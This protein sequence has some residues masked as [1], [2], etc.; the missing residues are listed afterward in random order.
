MGGYGNT[1]MS[2]DLIATTQRK[3][4]VGLGATGLSC[5]RYLAQ[6][7]ADFAVWDTRS[8]PPGLDEL[9]RIAP[10]APVFTGEQAP[11]SVLEGAAELVVSPGV[12]LDV[13]AIAAAAEAGVDVIGD[14]DLFIR[15]ARAP[16]I[17]I[18]GSNAKSTVTAM[19][20]AMAEAAGLNVGVGGN[21]G[22]PA[23]DLLDDARELYV[24]ELS[25]FQLERSQPLG[26][27]VATVLNISADHL[28]RHG[29][30]TRYHAAKHRIFRQ[31]RAAVLHRDDPLTLPLVPPDVQQ[32]SW[33]L[34]EP[35][36][37]GFGL[38]EHEGETWLCR[39]FDAWLPVNELALPGRHNVANALAALVLGDLAGLPLEPMLQAL[40]NFGG[41]PHRCQRVADIDGV[42]YIDD[43]KGTNTAATVA[44][45]EGLGGERDIVLI[46]GGQAKGADLSELG[47]ALAAHGRALVTLG[48]AAPELENLFADALP[49]ERADSMDDAVTRAAQIA[50]AGQTV[51]L[52]PACASLDMFDNYR[53]RGDAFVAAVRAL[54]GDA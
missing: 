19:V 46:A 49:T 16:V 26:L 42:T 52:S 18:T 37:K 48:E 39:G 29:D 11:V 3:V 43:S 10:D 45:L 44:A 34:G 7:G 53:A 25:S 21:L 50:E 36:L 4:V 41:L 12:A 8:E 2:Q 32:V 24:L 38:R 1:A 54:G 23:L 5:A 47:P 22:P 27:A 20:G 51:L 33:R 14:V 28:D 30:M 15:E 35:E 13:P 6:R 9:R 31:C 17:G 40:R